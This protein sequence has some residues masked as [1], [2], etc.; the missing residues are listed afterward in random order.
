MELTRTLYLGGGAQWF[1]CEMVTH[2][3]GFA[4]DCVAQNMGAARQ[5]SHSPRQWLLLLSQI[6][7]VL[8]DVAA[9]C[10][11]VCL[12]L[13][14]MLRR[15]GWLMTFANDWRSCGQDSAQQ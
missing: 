14:M 8:I 13:H 3:C 7:S 11:R 5:V 10:S 2:A 9:V 12:L 4:H 1:M 15:R 6:S